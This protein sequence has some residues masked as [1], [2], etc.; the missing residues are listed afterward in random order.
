MQDGAAPDGAARG[1]FRTDS[2][3]ATSRAVASSP[4][5]L[6]PRRVLGD[7]LDAQRHRRRR[8]PAPRLVLARLRKTHKAAL[9]S[10]DRWPDGS[11]RGRPHSRSRCQP[12]RR[13]AS[14][15]DRCTRRP[16]RTPSPRLVA[17]LSPIV[18]PPDQ[19]AAWRSTRDGR[20]APGSAGE[21]HGLLDGAQDL[22]LAAAPASTPVRSAK[23]HR[24][25]R[26]PFW[27]C[28][29]CGNAVI[30]ARKLPAILAFLTFMRA[31]GP[32]LT[33]ADWRPNS[34]ALMRVSR[35]GAARFP[36][37][38]S[39]RHKPSR[40]P[41][42]SCISP[43]G[44][45]MT[46]AA[47][48]TLPPR[49]PA[50]RYVHDQD[51]V[52]AGLPIR[53]GIAAASLPLFGETSGTWRRPYS[54]RTP[55]AAIAASISRCW[56]T[57]AA[58]HRKGI[59]LRPSA[60]AGGQPATA[61]RP[62]SVRAVFNRL[63]RFMSFA[64]AAGVFDLGLLRQADL[65]AW[66]AHLQTGGARASPG[67]GA[68]RRRDRPPR[69]RGSFKPAAAFG[70]R[71]GVA[72]RPPRSPVVR[73]SPREQHATH[74]GAGDRGHAALVT[75]LHRRFR[76]RYLA[77]R[78]E[79][80]RLEQR[81]PARS[82][83]TEPVAPRPVVVVASERLDDYLRERRATAAACPSGPMTRASSAGSIRSRSTTR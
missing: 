42:G 62:G 27:G 17:A 53:P 60:R 49:L 79:L 51:S 72:R 4:A 40:E 67:R 80:N 32:G 18:L 71:P 5:S 20:R 36:T 45:R 54:A 19:E 14:R 22:W 55:G 43:G 58:C 74:P 56:P 6:I 44:P 10:E 61:P 52:L 50:S 13:S 7:C 9:V 25:V 35:A 12:L 75:A 57:G 37:P 41:S 29:D 31:S 64:E 26:V 30:T 63:R 47:L 48:P 68:A 24:R 78:T 34:V 23:G 46:A 69:A 76:A 2:S 21:R 81:E 65:D 11:V 38:S 66:L 1:M 82:T 73:L 77:A 3:G 15:R 16:S 28:L 33:A 39:P 8:G 70:S 83:S 59:P